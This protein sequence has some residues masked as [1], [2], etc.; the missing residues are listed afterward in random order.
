MSAECPHLAQRR[1]APSSPSPLVAESAAS[2]TRTTLSAMTVSTSSA[3]S[4]LSQALPRLATAAAL[5]LAAFAFDYLRRRR[6]GA[7]RSTPPEPLEK[8]HDVVFGN[9][10]DKDFGEGPLMNPPVTVSDPYFWMRDDHRNDP[11]VLE[12]L[13][14]ENAYTNHTTL[15]NR[16]FER[17]IYHELLSHYVETDFSVPAKHANYVYY[18]STVKGKSY[19]YF[20]RKPIL[21]DGSHGDEHVMLDV[22]QLATGHK[23]CS[24]GSHSVSPDHNILA[25][26]VDFTGYETFDVYFKDLTTGQLLHHDTIRAT[27]GN[28]DWG[29]DNSI[30]YYTTLDEAHRPHKMWSHVMRTAHPPDASLPK[31]TCLYTETDSQFYLYFYK[32]LSA[33]FILVCS[34]ASTLSESRFLDLEHPQSGLRLFR[35]R[36]PHVLYSVFHATDDQFY[37][38]ANVDGATNFKLM[39]TSA[40]H[41]EQWHDFLPYNK[42]RKINSV[43]SFKDFAVLSGRES[44]YTQLWVLP[45]H[46]PHKMYLLPTEEEA[47][48]VRIGTNYEYDANVLRYSYSSLTTPTREYEYSISGKESVCLKEDEVPNYDGQFYKSERIEATS[49]DGTNVPIS[50]VY[51]A[52]AISE[53]GPNRL[54]LYGYGSYEASI[55]PSFSMTRLP[56][57]NRGVI[58]AIA[59]IRGGGE[60]GREWY[61]SARF[62][63]K[64]KT[65]EDFCACAEHLVTI[66]RTTP[67]LLSIEGRSAGGLLIG[68]VLNMRP[69]LFKAA[70]AGVPFVDVL[71]TMSD[72]SIPLTTGEWQEWGN[73][74]QKKFFDAIKAYCPYSNVAPK[75][76]PAVL[77]L[78]GLYD[79]RVMYSEAAKWAAKLRKNTTR[80]D[81]ILL[82]V[83]MSSG[84]FSA[85]NR[86][87]YL[88]EKAFDTAWVLRQLGAPEHPVSLPST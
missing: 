7:V 19:P 63:T 55:D 72:P 11:A 27:S 87:S 49:A 58:F 1:S 73:P 60:F 71:N 29:K 59:H 85:S 68:A 66:G 61:E 78:A 35:E 30:V 88:S 69:E 26:A 77:I 32:S 65:F 37:V 62:E 5:G 86:Y 2:T 16:P 21:H 6:R 28:V 34:D 40:A 50:L 44:G 22:N 52:K 31:D 54:H 33:R 42:G 74:H 67:K 9:V 15:S 75:P 36:Q 70:I 18:H 81:P 12:H 83:D 46:D 23:H 53:H 10:P 39:R 48:V 14:Q 51:N 17:R 45:A 64:V 13:R 84:H 38:T 56:M 57:L 79:P 24:L 3:S 8:P 41:P 4:P 80:D 76:Y 82:K 20:C 43:T 25:Y 47:H